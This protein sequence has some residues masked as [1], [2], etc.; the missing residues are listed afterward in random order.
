MT[1][2]APPPPAQR[3]GDD[4]P[5]PLLSAAFWIMMA[6]CLLCVV[7]GVLVVLLGPWLTGHEAHGPTIPAHAAS[8]ARS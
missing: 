8:P 3:P 7:S 2:P 1:D 6:F 4:P 5:R